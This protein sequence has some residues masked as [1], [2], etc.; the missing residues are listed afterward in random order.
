MWYGAGWSVREA[1][2]WAEGQ[3]VHLWTKVSRSWCTALQ[4]GLPVAPHVRPHVADGTLVRICKP[5]SPSSGTCYW[6]DTA[7]C[8]L[9]HRAVVLARKSNALLCVKHWYSLWGLPTQSSLPVSVNGCV[10]QID[11]ALGVCAGALHTHWR[12]EKDFYQDMKK[13]KVSTFLM[14]PLAPLF[15]NC[16]PATLTSPGWGLACWTVRWCPEDAQICCCTPKC[17]EHCFR[18][19]PLNITKACW[20]LGSLLHSHQL[21]LFAFQRAMRKGQ[22]QPGYV[23]GKYWAWWVSLSHSGS[24]REECWEI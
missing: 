4:P 14:G 20:G 7:E 8:T 3:C 17:K 15:S 24:T 1:G 10:T 19:S 23:N 11:V 5:G 6:R 13:C 2:R 9:L 18:G 21:V 16:G 12:F 22:R